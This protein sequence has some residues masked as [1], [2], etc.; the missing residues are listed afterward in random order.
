MTLQK[1]VEENKA[2]K[3]I[4]Y[5]VVGICKHSIEDMMIC[6]LSPLCLSHGK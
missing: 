3:E 1:Y 4:E 2:K 6:S 5:N